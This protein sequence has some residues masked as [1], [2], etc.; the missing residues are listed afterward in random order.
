MTSQKRYIIPPDPLKVFILAL[1][2][3]GSGT[4]MLIGVDHDFPVVDPWLLFVM[5]IVCLVLVS[6]SYVLDAEGI[7]ARIMFLPF[8]RIRWEFVNQILLF[9]K[10]NDDPR[11]R[12]ETIF[13]VTVKG[14]NEFNPDHDTPHTY[15]QRY[16]GIISKITIPRKRKHIVKTY[17]ENLYGVV[18]EYE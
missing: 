1:C 3:F 4:T 6:K 5:S 8:H 10:T 14:C 18:V 13:I 16:R 9:D 12:G 15:L 2:V 17:F 7:T 11:T